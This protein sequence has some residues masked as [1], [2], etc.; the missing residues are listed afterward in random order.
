[1]IKTS[2]EIIRGKVSDAEASKM[3]LYTLPHVVT[4]RTDLQTGL[5]KLLYGES[6]DV[7][8]V[9]VDDFSRQ[10]VT[11]MNGHCESERVVTFGTA[12]SFDGLE[13]FTDTSMNINERGK[14]NF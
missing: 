1:M 9:M 11:V 10:V 6:V 14:D 7:S 13:G 3:V 12:E 5:V 4:L 8:A 2:R